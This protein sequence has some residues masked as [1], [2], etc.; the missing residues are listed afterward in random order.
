MSKIVVS[1]YDRMTNSGEYKLHHTSKARGYISRKLFKSQDFPID[2]YEGHFGKGFV[3]H[4]PVYYSTQY[5]DIE[6][7][8][9]KE[10]E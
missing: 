6:Y 5:H 2:V 4:I 3:A 9:K 8:I 1:E 10:G 7:W